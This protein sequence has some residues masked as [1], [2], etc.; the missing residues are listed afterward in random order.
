MTP[1]RRRELGHRLVDTLHDPSFREMFP[2]AKIVVDFG[3]GRP[4]DV[5]GGLERQDYQPG[6][7]PSFVP[8]TPARAPLPWWVGPLAWTLAALAT[9]GAV[10][11]AR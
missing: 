5:I 7:M 3:D 2:S 10:A 9:A 4:T 1:D 6:P 8:Y 11:V